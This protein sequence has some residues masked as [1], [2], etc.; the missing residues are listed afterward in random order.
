MFTFEQPG[1]REVTVARILLRKL[2]LF[3]RQP[4]LAAKSRYRITSKVRREVVDLFFARV[5]G[6][7]TVVVTEENAEKLQLLCDELG[8]AGFDDEI[9]RF[10]GGDWKVRKD[11]VGL[12]GRVDRHDVIIEELQ[13]RVCALQ[14]ELQFQRGVQERVEEICRSD[15]TRQITEVK[16][17]GVA[18]REDVQRLRSELKEKASGADA[19]ALSEEAARLKTTEAAVAIPREFPF[20]ARNPLRGIAANMY[21]SV[22]VKVSSIAYKLGPREYIEVGSGNMMCIRQRSLLHIPCVVARQLLSSFEECPHYFMSQDK[23]NSWIIYEFKWRVTPTS[24]TIMSYPKG[25]GGNH[26]KSWVLEVSNDRS[27][28]SWAA[29]DSRKDNFDLNDSCAI[30][31]FAIRAP[32]SGSFRFVRLRQTGKNHAGNDYLAVARL[33]IFGKAYIK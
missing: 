24:Y 14:R 5:M 31:N 1:G 15:V 29:I 6:D 32:Q 12:S 7:D 23:P 26:L 19:A 11:L 13:R 9:R 30:C 27:E 21:G 10:F 2:Q 18:L 16:L 8:F 33:E 28:D 4:E 3:E 20:C 17:E 25:P 22:S